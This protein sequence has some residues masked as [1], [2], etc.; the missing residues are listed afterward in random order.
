MKIRGKAA[1]VLIAG[2]L[3]LSTAPVLA[4]G[5]GNPYED[6]QVGLDYVVYQPAYTA[7]L[8]QVHFGMHTCAAG[9]DEALDVNYS[10][11]K[12][13][14]LLTESASTNICPQNM[15]LIKGAVRTVVNKPGAGTLQ[16][17]QVVVISFGIE[18]AQLNVFFS[19][20]VPRATSPGSAVISPVLIDPNIVRYAEIS[21]TNTI[22][23]TV[24][25]PDKWTA[26]IANP[27]IVSFIPGKVREFYISNPGL[28]PLKK[29]KTIV[30]L[31]HSGKNIA[32]TL[33]VY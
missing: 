19:L 21:Q 1:A 3:V 12:K 28:R 23:F 4:M 18:R 16:A 30:T 17:T 15:M 22:S 25:D 8:A 13:S 10:S 6:A 9:Q 14:I 32:F 31:H 5:S 2:L 24:T 33:S 11:G 29:G 26:T 20:L 27:K 7:G